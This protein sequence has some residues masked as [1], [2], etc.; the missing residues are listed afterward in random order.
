VIVL[1]IILDGLPGDL[2]VRRSPALHQHAREL[3]R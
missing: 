3:P 1:V 2:R